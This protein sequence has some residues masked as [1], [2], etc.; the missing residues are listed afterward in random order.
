M[1]TDLYISNDKYIF[2]VVYAG[3]G[4]LEPPSEFKNPLVLSVSLAYYS[5]FSD[6][7]SPMLHRISLDF[8]PFRDSSEIKSYLEVFLKILFPCIA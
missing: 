2:Q 6:P 7:N 5:N 8:S 4:S 1:V 3:R